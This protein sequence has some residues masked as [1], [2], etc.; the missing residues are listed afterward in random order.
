M[1]VIWKVEKFCT[2]KKFFISL[3]IFIWHF[4][5]ISVLSVTSFTP[6]WLFFF[7]FQFLNL[8][9]GLGRDPALELG[10]EWGSRLF[11]I[12]GLSPFHSTSRYTFFFLS[13]PGH[14]YDVCLFWGLKNL[15]F[16]FPSIFSNSFCSVG[17][18]PG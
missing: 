1:K 4:L 5:V 2:T 12:V 3:C 7:C 15:D 16:S 9:L 10:L 6:V 14:L 17:F 11:Y 13:F 8:L 18:F